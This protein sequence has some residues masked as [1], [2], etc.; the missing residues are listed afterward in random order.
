MN[1][2]EWLYA[3]ANKSGLAPALFNGQELEATYNEFSSRVASIGAS[4]QQNYRVH[5]GDRVA[6]FMSNSTSYLELLYGILWI[7][8]VAVP[9][10]YKLHPKEASWILEDSEAKLVF[11]LK[12]TD[13]GQLCSSSFRL[14]KNSVIRIGKTKMAELRSSSNSSRPISRFSDDLAWLFYTS[15][16]TGK[17]KGV[18]ISHGNLMAMSL[19]YPIDVDRVDSQ[20]A[21]LYAAPMSHGAGLY[22]FIHV[23]CGA[24]HVVPPSGGF[25]AEEIFSLA[26]TIRHVSLFAAP[27]MVHRMVRQAK[28]HGEDTS[29]IKCIVYGG[30]PMYQADIVEAIEVL[31]PK[32]AHIYG[33]GESPMTITALSR[34]AMTKLAE[35]K[36]ANLLTTVGFAQSCVQVRIADD[37]GSTLPSEVVGEVLVKGATVMKGYWRNPEATDATLSEGWLKTGDLGS[38]D[39]HGY[40]TLTDRSK[41]VIISG[42]SNIYPREV[43]E[44]LLQHSDVREASVIGRSHPE[45]GEEVVAVVV[46]AQGRKLCPSKLNDFCNDRIAGFKRPR[47]YYEV[48]SLPKNNYG[49]I[50]KTELRQQFGTNLV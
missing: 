5:P 47:V 35:E 6:L 39:E 30:G 18:M 34:Q 25:D 42:G 41:D 33:Q 12:D 7:G 43:E 14:G 26:K 27:T 11:V 40:L 24:R 22:N 28:S 20:D 4:L 15:G 13:H 19:C 31:G 1:I 37:K 21:T 45:W 23:R 48:Q 50:L 38:L 8:A 32:F 2:A 44:V 9:I 29:G 16:T 49:K 36:K 17:P 46:M 3:T 10:N